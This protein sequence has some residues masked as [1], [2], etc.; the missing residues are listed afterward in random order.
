MCSFMTLCPLFRSIFPF[1]VDKLL[2]TLQNSAG[3]IQHVSGMQADGLNK[4]CD[5]LKAQAQKD[6]KPWDKLIVQENGQ[7]FRVLNPSHGDL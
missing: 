5:D 3:A 1:L 7:N 2:V 6:G 4:V